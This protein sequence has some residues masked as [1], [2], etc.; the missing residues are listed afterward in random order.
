MS[1]FLGYESPNGYH[2][3]EKGRIKISA[4]VLAQVADILKVP[5]DALFLNR[6]H[7]NG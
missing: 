5:I 6:N 1:R 7:Q 2:Y 4:E 3:I